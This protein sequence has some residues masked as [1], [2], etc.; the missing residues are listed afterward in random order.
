MTVAKTPSL[1]LCARAERSVNT[2]LLIRPIS[3]HS[4]LVPSFRT[5]KRILVMRLA[6][7][8]RMR[9]SLPSGSVRR[10]ISSTCCAAWSECCTPGK[11]ACGKQSRAAVDGSFQAHIVI[12]QLDGFR[13]QRQQAH[14]VA[15]AEHADL[16]LRQDQVVVI[17]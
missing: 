8:S 12:Q 7:R 6:R 16:R 14:F 4:Y 5:A 11:S 15:L 3:A 10:N 2:S 1:T 17:Q 13:S 9:R